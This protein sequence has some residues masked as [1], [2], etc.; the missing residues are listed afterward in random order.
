MFIDCARICKSYHFLP[1]HTS[2]LVP[3][4]HLKLCETQGL[5]QVQ[6]EKKTIK[7]ELNA[8]QADICYTFWTS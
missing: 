8:H 4:F 6:S 1:F 5:S 7:T 2:V 3:C